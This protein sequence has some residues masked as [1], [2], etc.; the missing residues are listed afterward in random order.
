MDAD[1]G[2]KSLFSRATKKALD[3]GCARSTHGA[4]AVLESDWGT[5]TGDQHLPAAAAPLVFASGSSTARSASPVR[6]LADCWL[7]SSSS[8]SGDAPVPVTGPTRPKRLKVKS[9]K[10]STTSRDPHCC[11]LQGAIYSLVK[12]LIDRGGA[13]AVQRW[14]GEWPGS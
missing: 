3:R 7:A 6:W 5:T 4:V 8:K 10:A 13:R 14:T 12:T 1:P 2:P 9:L 11:P